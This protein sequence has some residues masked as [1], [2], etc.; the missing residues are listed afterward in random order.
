MPDRDVDTLAFDLFVGHRDSISFAA[1]FKNRLLVGL[2]VDHPD[3]V[4]QIGALFHARVTRVR[5]A[6]GFAEIDLGE[7]GSA[8]LKT[9]EL[10]EGQSVE[11]SWQSPAREGK[12]AR[13]LFVKKIESILN[14]PLLVHHGLNALE[15]IKKHPYFKKFSAH[16]Q[17]HTSDNVECFDLDDEL[18]KLCAQTVMIKN[19]T[20]I[21][22]EQ[23]SAFYT[24]DINSSL[25]PMEANSVALEEISRQL[26]LR[27]ISGT[28]VI[29]LAGDKRKLA[30]GLVEKMRVL[31][32]LDPCRVQ[33][34]GITKLGL[35]ELTRE[36]NGWPLTQIL[37]TF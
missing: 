8:R 26:C 17:I 6:L 2:E 32:A 12:G 19:K 34:F 33:V 18:Q 37:N 29:D 27:N 22:F 13:V 35:M 36:R 31:T 16:V 28:I 5:P 9:K 10:R 30:A 21:I 15:R 25:S 11:V 3:F 20:S 23:T 1:L 7:H 24:V 4:P 14:A